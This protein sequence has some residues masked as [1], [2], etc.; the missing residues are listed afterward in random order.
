MS[1]VTQ[2]SDNQTLHYILQI[3]SHPY[4]ILH[5]R[6]TCIHSSIYPYAYILLRKYRTLKTTLKSYLDCTYTC[7]NTAKSHLSKKVLL[8]DRLLSKVDQLGLSLFDFQN[9]HI[10]G[11]REEPL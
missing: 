7:N 2:N 1:K 4:T 9:P 11:K 5:L 10:G 3:Y 6:K 8:K